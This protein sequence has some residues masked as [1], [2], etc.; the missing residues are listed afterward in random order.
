[1]RG[2][3]L[4]ERETE[5]LAQLRVMVATESRDGQRLAENLG[6][7]PIC[8]V[9]VD[10][11]IPGIVVTWRRYATSTQLRFIHEAILDLVRRRGVVR[12]LGDD[13]ALPTIH[14]E[15]QRWIVADW[16]PR[17]KEA[18]VR[19]AASKSPVSYFG[20]LAVERVASNAP[21]P[22]R[23]FEDMREARR[24]LQNLAY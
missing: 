16:M 9:I 13:T 7:N 14:A 24:W 10:E 17:A 12:V 23:A 4:P 21:W 5:T 20:R 2:Q 22:L 18:G 11:S 8:T 1:M 15:D 19:V 6:D 3:K